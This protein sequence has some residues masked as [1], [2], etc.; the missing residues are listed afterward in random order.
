VIPKITK[1]GVPGPVLR[2]LVGPGKAN[3]HT[4]PHLVAGSE[5]VFAAYEGGEL[6]RAQADELAAWI[7]APRLRFGVSVTAPRTEQDPATGERVEVGRREENVWHCSLSI[8]ATEGDLGDERWRAVAAEFAETMG[9]TG[10]DGKAPCRW[11][12]VHH[13]RSAN[14]N[15]HIHLVA[16]TV[17]EDGTRWEGRYRDYVRAQAACRGLEERH[18]LTRLSGP[19]AGVSE[20]G[21][22]RAEI[23]RAARAGAELTAPQVLGQRVRAAA[24]VSTSEA[25]FVRRVRAEG[26]VIK[27]RYAKDSTSQVVGYRVALPAERNAGAWRFYGGGT[28]GRDLSLPRLR[29][30]WPS[31]QLDDSAA[32]VGEWRAAQAGRAVVAVGG[33]ETRGLAPD[34]QRTATARLAAYNDRL[35]GLPLGDEAGWA[36]AARQSAG[37]VAAWASHDPDHGPELARAARA[38][39]RSAQTRKPGTAAASTADSAR[40]AALVLAAGGGGQEI[41]R[42]L[43]RTAALVARRH[44]QLGHTGEATHLAAAAVVPLRA[45]AA[46]RKAARTAQKV[47]RVIEAE[48]ERPYGLDGPTPGRGH[49]LG[50]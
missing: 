45:A 37:A 30:S 4:S 33:R 3:E 15:D 14:G 5:A 47:E 35:T 38:L 7:D 8:A 1:A 18:G 40:A 22:T 36:E 13:G 6:S 19:A 50:R 32:A 27:P 43:T 28:L 46:M 24:L 29:E 17:R 21:A 26:I 16:S 34:A 12:A 49:D 20:R 25:E 42:E 11:V 10:A 39:A 41:G 48:D 44:Q 31:A 9:L 23:T 2:Y